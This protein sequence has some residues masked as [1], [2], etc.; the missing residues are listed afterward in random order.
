MIHDLQ[1]QKADRD[2]IDDARLIKKQVADCKEILYQMSAGAG[3][4]RGEEQRSFTIDEAV[5]QIL[6]ELA[7]EERKRIE[8]EISCNRPHLRMGFRTLCRTLKGLLRNG[9][10][11]ST[12]ADPVRMKWFEKDEQLVIEVVD[13]GQGM[14]PQ[15]LR[16]AMEPFFSTKPTGMGLGLFLAKTM[17]EQ[18]GGDVRVDS[19]PE[20]GTTATVSLAINRIT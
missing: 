3:E 8:A 6:S 12:A 15:V 7:P 16:Q 13:H 19:A 10:E 9:L 18:F 17:A 14:R 11:A 4:L 5:A 20:T 2:L 1:R